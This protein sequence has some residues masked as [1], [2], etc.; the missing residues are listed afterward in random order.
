MLKLILEHGLR[1]SGVLNFASHPWLFIGIFLLESEWK[2]TKLTSLCKQFGTSYFLLFL[3]EIS[4]SFVQ[5]HYNAVYSRLTLCSTFSLDQDG[6]VI[7]A[8]FL[9]FWWFF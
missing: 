3:E 1:K 8:Y 6:E 5:K 4:Q 9:E 2:K 7:L